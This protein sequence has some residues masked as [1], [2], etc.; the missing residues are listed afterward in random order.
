MTEHAHNK[1]TA[2]VKS[3]EKA[4]Q[5]KDLLEKSKATIQSLV[6]KHVSAERLLKVAWACYARTPALKECSNPSIV[7]GVVRAS[8]LGLEIGTGAHLVPFRN[9]NTGRIEAQLIIDYR[10]LVS[11]VKRTGNVKNVEARAVFRGDD[12][13]LT[14]GTDGAKVEHHPDLDTAPSKENLRG[15]YMIATLGSGDVHVEWMAKAE[16]DTIRARS[17]ASNNGPWVTDYVE[18]AKKTVVRRGTKMLEQSSEELR[19]AFD[20]DADRPTYIEGVMGELPESNGE[21]EEDP[22]AAKVAGLKQQLE[23]GKRK[24]PK[25]KRRKSQPATGPE[26]D[27][28]EGASPEVVAEIENPGGQTATA[29]EEPDDLTPLEK[30]WIELSEIIASRPGVPDDAPPALIESIVEKWLVAKNWSRD[31]LADSKTAGVILSMAKAAT[32]RQTEK[33]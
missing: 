31:S 16:I 33:T 7:N 18:M 23:D 8:E 12:F 14:Y 26:A 2:I 3:S 1:E 6:P 28:L 9:K 10:G 20:L 19:I 32:F 17:R 27:N 30:R 22:G 29:I 13:T 11:L 21:A 24:Q 15:C 4:T 25:P 5:L